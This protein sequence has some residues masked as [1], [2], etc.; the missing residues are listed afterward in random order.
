MKLPLMYSEYHH[1]RAEG[2]AVTHEA[3]RLGRRRRLQRSVATVSDA[4]RMA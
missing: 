1:W 2:G 4:V 3:G